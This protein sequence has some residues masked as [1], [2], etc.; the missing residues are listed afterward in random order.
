MKDELWKGVVLLLDEKTLPK[1][2]IPLP[3][4]DFELKD[5]CLFHM[6]HLP[7]KLIIQLEISQALR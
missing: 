6:R 4:D 2:R 1:G 5:D 3:I 7:G